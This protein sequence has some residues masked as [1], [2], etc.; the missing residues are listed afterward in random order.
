MDPL[1]VQSCHVTVNITPLC[2]I[3]L[4]VVTETK[5]VI[6]P[7]GTVVV[8]LES[9]TKVNGAS[10]P[11]NCTSETPVKPAPVI[12]TRVPTGPVS[13]VSAVIAGTMTLKLEALFPVPPGFV[14]EIRLLVA[15]A[16]TAVVICV[17]E[18]IEKVVTGVEPKLTLV[19]PVKFD[20]VMVTVAPT[21]PDVGEN[22]VT[23]GTGG[24]GGGEPLSV[25]RAIPDWV[26][27]EIEVK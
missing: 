2:K 22:D 5:P 18:S 13:G 6:A 3:P 8:I 19:A 26:I 17:S 15:P 9:L 1:S 7:A 25:N 23:A 24:G 14:T 4:G 12:V 16:G 21:S 20:P 27:P 10:T 11:L